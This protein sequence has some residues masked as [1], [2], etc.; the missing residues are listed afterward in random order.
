MM[1]VTADRWCECLAVEASFHSFLCS[2]D[3]PPSHFYTLAT[4][5]THSTRTRRPPA[6]IW[7]SE[8]CRRKF[9]NAGMWQCECFTARLA[10]CERFAELKLECEMF[11][12]SFQVIV[13]I[14]E[15]L[16]IS[17]GRCNTHFCYSWGYQ[18]RR[19]SS[20][21]VV[22]KFGEK[23]WTSRGGKSCRGKLQRKIWFFFKFIIFRKIKRKRNFIGHA[24]R[25]RREKINCKSSRKTFS[26][27]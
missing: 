1:L 26:V 7:R 23:I 6:R 8:K 9:S 16:K 27:K 25:R 3:F 21:K 11:Y 24:I 5:F 22:R 15:Q 17:F 13:S 19:K 18:K 20:R 14:G 12:F 2:K 10:V 4:Y